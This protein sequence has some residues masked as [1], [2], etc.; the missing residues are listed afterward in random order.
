MHFQH[1]LKRK[2]SCKYSF[3]G[4][5]KRVHSDKDKAGRIMSRVSVEG[6]TT[7]Y[8]FGMIMKTH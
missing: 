1:P 5:K 6:F 2:S 7:K 4:G 8:S 3:E